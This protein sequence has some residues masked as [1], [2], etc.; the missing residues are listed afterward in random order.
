MDI[1]HEKLKFKTIEN[2]QNIFEND[3]D[4]FKTV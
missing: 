3:F 4:N 1:F 2:M